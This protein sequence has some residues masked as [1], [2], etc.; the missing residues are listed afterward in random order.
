MG[1]RFWDEET[2]EFSSEGFEGWMIFGILG[3]F[4]FLYY[5]DM[6]IN[7]Y[8]MTASFNDSATTPYNNIMYGGVGSSFWSGLGFKSAFGIGQWVRVFLNW[9]SWFVVMMT[10]CMTL[11]PHFCGRGLALQH[12]CLL[13]GNVAPHPDCLFDRYLVASGRHLQRLHQLLPRLRLLRQVRCLGPPHDTQIRGYYRSLGHRHGSRFH[14]LRTRTRHLH[15]PIRGHPPA[16][17]PLP[18]RTQEGRV[19]KGSDL[20]RVPQQRAQIPESD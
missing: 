10:W 1:P 14:R 3:F 18:C 13:H 6:F 20:E 17:P 4:N 15:R 8:V 5:S 16:C 9:F 11:V 12:R 2:I 19:R 7:K